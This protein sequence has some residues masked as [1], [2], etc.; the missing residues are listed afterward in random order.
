[1]VTR[2]KDDSIFQ[3]FRANKTKQNKFYVDNE[4]LVGLR[5]GKN[6][7]EGKREREK[8]S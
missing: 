1:M 7:R 8:E 6:I 2:K 3:D 4:W 5:V